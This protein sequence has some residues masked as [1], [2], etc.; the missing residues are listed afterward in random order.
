ML[1]LMQSSALARR[2]VLR[3]EGRADIRFEL[4]CASPFDFTMIEDGKVI[5][6][7]WATISPQQAIWGGTTSMSLEEAWQ[8]CITKRFPEYTVV[9]L[10]EAFPPEDM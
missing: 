10:E 3:K 6:P 9:D 8:R 2:A 7:F 4:R 1:K 5:G